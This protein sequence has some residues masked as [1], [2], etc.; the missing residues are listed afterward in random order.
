LKKEDFVFPQLPE[1]YEHCY[2]YRPPKAGEYYLTSA[3]SIGK[4]C[5]DFECRCFII[6]KTRPRVSVGCRYYYIGGRLCAE[7]DIDLR[8]EIDNVRHN[9]GNYFLTK[10]QAEKMRY[11]LIDVLAEEV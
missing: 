4:A 11:K 6:K 2:E 10:E 1:G 9:V 8:H 5:V 3:D 7:S